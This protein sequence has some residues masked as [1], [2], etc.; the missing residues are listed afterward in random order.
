MTK[1]YDYNQA[2]KVMQG[3]DEVWDGVSKIMEAALLNLPKGIKLNDA[4]KSEWFECTRDHLDTLLAEATREYEETIKEYE[5][6]ES[7]A[8]HNDVVKTFNGSR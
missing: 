8:Y 1:E 2:C 7:D 6:A 5:Q 3:I 4:E